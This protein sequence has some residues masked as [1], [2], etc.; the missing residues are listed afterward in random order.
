[1]RKLSVALPLI[2]VLLACSCAQ[3]QTLIKAEV[4]KTGITADDRLTYKLTVT[5]S[6]KA[7]PRPRLPDFSGFSVIANSQDSRVSLSQGVLK[8]TA[9]Y[10]FILSPQ[11][12]GILKIGP[13]RISVEGKDY[14]SNAFDIEVRPGRARPEASLPGQKSSPSSGPQAGKEPQFTL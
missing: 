12:T 3:A 1:M 6:A 14:S 2:A 8:T 11:K 13:A 4:D 10:T 5:S 7:I 9:S